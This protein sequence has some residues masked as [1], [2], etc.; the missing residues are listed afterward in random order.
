MDDV[1]QLLQA[2]ISAHQEFLDEADV[3]ILKEGKYLDRGTPERAY[4]HHGYMVALQDVI[5]LLLTP[6]KEGGR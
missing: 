4:W 1:V 2:R 6:P 5:R 3:S